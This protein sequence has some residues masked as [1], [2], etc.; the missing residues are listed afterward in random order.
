MVLD[1]GQ[2]INLTCPDLPSGWAL[3]ALAAPEG[4]SAAPGACRRGIVAVTVLKFLSRRRCMD[5]RHLYEIRPA[6]ARRMSWQMMAASLIMP[7]IN[8][9]SFSS[10]LRT[11]NCIHFRRLST[12]TQEK[13]NLR[14]EGFGG[15]KL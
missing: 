2:V 15:T 4:P 14:R 3:L 8:A 12:R 5:S 1:F 11:E 9:G 10:F 13:T 7:L 6:K